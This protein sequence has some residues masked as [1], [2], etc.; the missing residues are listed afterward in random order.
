MM[1]KFKGID[2]EV[3]EYQ[4]TADNMNLA[5]AMQVKQNIQKELFSNRTL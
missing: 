2:T 1:C 4:D 5:E 3:N